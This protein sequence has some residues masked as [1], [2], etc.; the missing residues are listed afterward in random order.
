LAILRLGRQQFGSILIWGT[1]G[2]I[3]AA[4]LLDIAFGSIVF[5]SLFVRRLLVTPGL[6]TGDY[7]QFFSQYPQ[8]LLS[9]SILKGFITNPYGSLSPPFLIGGT[10]FHNASDSANAN[11]WADAFANFGPAG[12]VVFSAIL[13]V[14]LW[15]FDSMTQKSSLLLASLMLALPVFTLSNSGLLTTLLT[16]GLLV[17]VVAAS[18]LPQESAAT[19]AQPSTSGTGRLPVGRRE[20]PMPLNA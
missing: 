9:H 12:V 18:F 17:G 14:I 1:T 5:T 7:F 10:Y 19:D 13:G 8:M 6:L 3:I 11:L 15:T 2:M 4:A 20:T 16:H